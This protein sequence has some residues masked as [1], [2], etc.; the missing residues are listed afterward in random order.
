MK[1]TCLLIL[2]SCLLSSTALAYD[3]Y[4]DCSRFTGLNAEQKSSYKTSSICVPIANVSGQDISV[5]MYN[6]PKQGDTRVIHDG[7]VGEF[8]HNQQV[9]R[10][11]TYEVIIHD[12]KGKIVYDSVNGRDA[13]VINLTGLMCEKMKTSVKCI[14]WLAIKPA[15]QMPYTGD[16]D[17][18]KPGGFN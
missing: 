14:P 7:N 10:G 1:H 5:T 9:K 6:S 16:E 15:E 2:S 4:N 18:K 3:G 12:A 13:D 8:T 17:N 11:Q